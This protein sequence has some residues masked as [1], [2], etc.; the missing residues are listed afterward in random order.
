MTSVR[1]TSLPPT[2]TKMFSFSMRTEPTTAV[3]RAPPSTY[4][5][6]APISEAAAVRWARAYCAWVTFVI[7]SICS[8]WDSAVVCCT[9]SWV[10]IGSDGSWYFTDATSSSRKSSLSISCFSSGRP[11]PVRRR[12]ANGS[13]PVAPTVGTVMVAS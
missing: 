13:A 10:F 5:T 8:I 3:D 11:V 7:A 2:S 4:S 9:S 12:S 1:A 6:S